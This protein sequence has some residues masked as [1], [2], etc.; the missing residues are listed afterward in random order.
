MNNYIKEYEFIVG[1]DITIYF[2]EESKIEFY[3]DDNLIIR[4]DP[5]DLAVVDAVY[6]K[7]MDLWTKQDAEDRAREELGC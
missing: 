3:K 2:T 6:N 7:M 1:C 4:I 5:T